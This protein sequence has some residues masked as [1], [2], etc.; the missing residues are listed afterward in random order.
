MG[1]LPEN[2]NTQNHDGGRTDPRAEPQGAGA[3]EAPSGLQERSALS[4]PTSAV[5]RTTSPGKGLVTTS[6]TWGGLCL[7]PASFCLRLLALLTLPSQCMHNALCQLLPVFFSLFLT[8]FCL[9]KGDGLLCQLIAQWDQRF[10]PH[11]T[12]PDH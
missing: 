11:S 10:R 4:L 5:Q 7:L 6:W 12:W 1:L 8:I 3:R 9:L 2:V